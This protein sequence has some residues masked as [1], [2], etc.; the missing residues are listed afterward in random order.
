M[1]DF[2]LNVCLFRVGAAVVLDAWINLQ[3]KRLILYYLFFVLPESDPIYCTTEMI[4]CMN[5]N[6]VLVNLI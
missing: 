5:L 2:F 1:D 6:I 4:C 3:L